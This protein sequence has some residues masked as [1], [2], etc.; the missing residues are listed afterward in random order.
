MTESGIHGALVVLDPAFNADA[1]ASALSI[2]ASKNIIRRHLATELDSLTQV[3]RYVLY[4]LD[5]SA[6]CDF[7]VLPDRRA[8]YEQRARQARAERK[9]TEK[10][11]SSAASGAGGRSLS[12]SFTAGLS[13]SGSHQD[14]LYAAKGS[15]G[16]AQTNGFRSS[17]KTS[18]HVSLALLRQHT[19]PR[20]S[21]LLLFFCFRLLLA[22]RSVA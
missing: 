2:P 14:D 18:L 6:Q 12:R 9:R 5:P 17:V 3:A 1:M 4:A 22:G 21:I 11:E 16:D 8:R 20:R 13:L 15:T 7:C 10:L 19:Q